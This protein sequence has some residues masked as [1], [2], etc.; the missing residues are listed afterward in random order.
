MNLSILDGWWG[1]ACDE[2]NGWGIPPVNIQDPGRRDAMEAD[3]IYDTLEEEVLP[4]YYARGAANYSAE[5]VRRCKRAMMTVIPQ[6]NMR[7]M[8]ADYAQGIYLPAAAQGERLAQH[9]F[10]GAKALAAWKERVRSLWSGTNLRLL[11][12]TSRDLPHAE[13]LRMR[14]AAQLN[15]LGANDV[16]VEFIAR[17]TLPA[18]NNEA[19]LLASSRRTPSGGQWSGVFVPTGEHESDGAA[20]FALDIPTEQ[21]GQFAIELRMRPQHELLSHPYE[22]GLMRSVGERRAVQR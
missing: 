17:R 16:S 7:R 20:V 5:W 10:A 18:T 6:F 3:L 12:G 14:V 11:Q 2:V 9:D 22:M 1:E 21:C 19:P 8:V 13:P 4:T 15:G